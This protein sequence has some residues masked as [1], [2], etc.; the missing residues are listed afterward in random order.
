MATQLFANNAASVLAS[1]LTS[2]AT[3]LTVTTGH[4]ARFP[5]P[6]GGDY[7]LATLCQQGS[8]GEINFEIVKVTARSTDSFTIVRAQESTTALAYNAGD[9]FELRLTKGT[10]EG[11]RDFLQAGTGAVTTRTI[12]TELRLKIH[13]AQF[14]AVGD[15]TDSTTA[16]QNAINQAT[17]VGGADVIIG[18][19]TH[20]LS[21]TLTLANNVRLIGQG[22]TS[23]IL[24]RTGSY[25]HTI[26]QT[27]GFAH[28]E[29]F[30]MQHGTILSAGDIALNY[31]QTNST[32]HINLVNT[33]NAFIKGNIIWRMPYGIILDGAINTKIYDNWV[34]GI[35]DL[36]YVAAQEG[37][38]DILFTGT[39]Q[40]CQL[41]KVK[42]NYFSGAVNST[43]NTTYSD[44]VNSVI[45][46][47][48]SNVGSQNNLLVLSC[49]DL[50]V[51]GNYF[52]RASLGLIRLAPSTG[53]SIVLDVRITDNL[54]DN[55]GSGPEGY[56]ITVTSD[57][58]SVTVLGLVIN[59]N[60]F[61][62]EYDTNQAIRIS[63]SGGVAAP[64]AVNV[65]IVGNSFFAHTGTPIVLSG[66]K[67]CIVADNTLQ[68]YNAIH[69]ALNTSTNYLY[70]AG[71]YV[72]GVSRDC[73]VKNNVIGGGGN[74][75]SDAA[76]Y[77]WDGVVVDPATINNTFKDNFYSS[78]ATTAG[79][80]RKGSTREENQHV[81]TAA[82]NYTMLS[83][84]DIFICNKTTGATTVVHLPY[85]PMVGAEKTI[86][87]GKGD[88]A[89]N[90]LIVG[91]GDGSTIDGAASINITTNYGYMK[92][93]FNGT[94]WN[95]IG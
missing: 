6:S 56:Q 9:K 33:Q 82:G 7:F 46:S 42:G 31:K 94:Q 21:A 61:N 14:G 68:N 79:V 15:G 20:L 75:A 49:E 34:E 29:G 30:F 5:S 18:A 47:Y 74:D 95:R 16:I 48:V 93:R 72:Y 45:K 58:S 59:G 40:Y 50:D 52:G 37:I 24:Y 44:G 83:S 10:M 64:T 43:R 67:S 65:Q 85:Y 51:S 2:V 28:I 81:L 84:T 78:I 36:N 55:A 92:F 41:A 69:V 35:W 8:A 12:Q 39:S 73:I 76:N 3:S 32:S 88:A 4:G 77:C 60:T 71:V 38:A 70:R 62:G 91:T 53:N 17:A 1:S 63:Q 80:F 19:G 27:S 26:T 22:G 89:A 11:L 86:K 66:A 13:A 25:G 87:D 54:F 57:T 23:T 90:T